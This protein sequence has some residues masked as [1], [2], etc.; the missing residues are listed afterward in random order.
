MRD[1]YT[2]FCD[3]TLSQI[4]PDLQHVC[5]TFRQCFPARI[6]SQAAAGRATMQ[7]AASSAADALE[8]RLTD[9][10]I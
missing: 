8:T 2:L 6:K 10:Q 4:A 1:A 3:S 7:I 5:N 9:D